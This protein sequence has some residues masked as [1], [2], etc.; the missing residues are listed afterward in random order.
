MIFVVEEVVFVL[1][2]VICSILLVW[3]RDDLSLPNLSHLRVVQIM[4]RTRYR[5]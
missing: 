2:V 4:N 1:K 3:F 5:I